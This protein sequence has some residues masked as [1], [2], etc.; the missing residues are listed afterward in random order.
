MNKT[1]IDCLGDN[2]I[3]IPLD[4]KETQKSE[5]NEKEDNS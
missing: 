2:G 4:V 1:G 3:C 5:D